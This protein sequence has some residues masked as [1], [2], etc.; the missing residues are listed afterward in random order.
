MNIEIKPFGFEKLDVWK[1]SRELVRSIYTLTDQFPKHEKYS[2]SNQIQRSVVSIPSNIAEGTS[3][4]S[5]KDFARFIEI[6][7]GSLTETLNHLY[8][9]LDLGYIK[10]ESLNEIKPVIYEIATKLSALRRYLNS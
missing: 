7:Y 10:Q 2:L 9:S 4:H 3:R 5:K 6:S 8:L 1:K